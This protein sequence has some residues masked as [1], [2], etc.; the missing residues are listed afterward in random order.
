MTAELLEAARRLIA[1]QLLSI[2]V[3]PVGVRHVVSALRW[4]V[5]VEASGGIEL[6]A[7][8]LAKL[9]ALEH[10]IGTEACA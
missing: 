1:A 6:A 9:R 10:A 8:A 4:Q 5:A 7:C 3:D 2:D